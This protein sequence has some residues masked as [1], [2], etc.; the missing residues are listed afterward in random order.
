MKKRDRFQ[1]LVFFTFIRMGRKSVFCLENML[2]GTEIL[3]RSFRRT[4]R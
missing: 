3:K 1:I 2:I 4:Q